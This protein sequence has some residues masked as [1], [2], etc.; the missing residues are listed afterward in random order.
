[1]DFKNE[2]EL[3][4]EYKIFLNVKKFYIKKKKLKLFIVI[5]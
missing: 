5:Y 2:Q 3:K 4:K 1:M